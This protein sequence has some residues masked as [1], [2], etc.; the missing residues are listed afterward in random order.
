M[1]QDYAQEWPQFFT[2]T[3][4]EW[5]HLLKENKYK[6]VIVDSLK[7]LSFQVLVGWSKTKPRRLTGRG[8]RCKHSCKL[9]NAG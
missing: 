5:K 2:A 8:V 9:T 7:F 6:N 4:Q 1:K 3:I